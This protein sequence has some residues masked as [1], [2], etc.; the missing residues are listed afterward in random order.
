MNDILSN[1]A[2]LDFLHYCLHDNAAVPVTIGSIDWD[3]LLKASEEAH[4]LFRS[5]DIF[6][7]IYYIYF[8]LM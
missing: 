4:G 6:V 8:M 7:L 5:K 2:T 3:A 1:K